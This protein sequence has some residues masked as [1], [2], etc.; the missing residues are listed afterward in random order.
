MSGRGSVG[1]GR[2]KGG[3]GGDVMVLEMWINV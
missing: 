3:L 1:R 2:K